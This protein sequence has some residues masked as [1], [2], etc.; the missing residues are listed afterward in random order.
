MAGRVPTRS[1]DYYVACV[2]KQYFPQAV[3]I[4]AR[5]RRAGRSA[6]LSYRQTGLGKQLKQASEQNATEAVIVGAEIESQQ[7]AVKALS[8]GMQRVV[9]VDQFFAGLAK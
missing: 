4:V 5:L 9:A 7:V 8:S 2:D 6:N 3:Q 1:L